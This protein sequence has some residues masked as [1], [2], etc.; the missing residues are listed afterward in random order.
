MGGV[1]RM[2]TKGLFNVGD[3]AQVELH[4]CHPILNTYVLIPSPNPHLAPLTS[5]WE[6]I[7][8]NA[9]AVDAYWTAEPWQQHHDA[10]FAMV[11]W[12]LL[13]CH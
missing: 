2:L 13:L 3:K 6:T 9:W 8:S 12:A 4:A 1:C 11:T 10:A 7:I 5:P